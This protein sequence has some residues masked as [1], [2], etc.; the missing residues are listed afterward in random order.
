MKHTQPFIKVRRAENLT[1]KDNSLEANLQLN[2]PTHKA[3]LSNSTL[4]LL[5]SNNPRYEGFYLNLNLRQRFLKGNFK[6]FMLGSLIDLT[7]PLQFLGSNLSLLKSILEGNNLICQEFKSA[8]NPLLIYN[9]ELLKRN[10]NVL[11]SEITNLLRYS[12]ILNKVWNNSSILSPSISEL[13]VQSIGTFSAIT[14][15]DLKNFSSLYLLNVSLTNLPNLNKLTELKLLKGANN[16]ATKNKLF[17]NQSQ[18]DH[19]EFYDRFSSDAENSNYMF[20]PPSTLYETEG[21]FLNAEGLS[22]RTMKLIFKKQAKSNWQILRKVLRSLNNNSNLVLNSDKTL[23][24]CDLKRLM[25]FKNYI[26]FQYQAT[27]TLTNI[28]FYL[29]TENKSFVISNPYSNF[30]SRLFKIK[31][32]K[33]KYWLDDFFNGGKDEYSHK[34]L[35]L[36]NCSRILRNKSTN[37]F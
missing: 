37:F 9:Y 25:N 34:S 18:Y 6:C 5:V 35:I 30:K 28:N 2:L 36:S 16:V 4:C 32:T 27:Y 26:Y 7:F 20:V 11:T 13:A 33:M 29:N 17:I 14:E 23:I 8:K 21:T 15:K 24:G 31:L 10:D 1:V 19:S 22:K 3:N 12:N